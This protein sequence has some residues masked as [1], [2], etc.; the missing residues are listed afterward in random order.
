MD[1]DGEEEP[2]TDYAQR[3]VVVVGGAGFIGRWLVRRL[4]EVGAQVF[5]LEADAAAARRWFAEVGLDADVGA[6][7]ADDAG[8]AAA[9]AARAPDIL[10]NLAAHGVL[11]DER[12]EARF[13]AVNAALPETLARAVASLDGSDWPGQRIVHAGSCSEY[14]LVRGV[15]TERS[16]TSPIAPYG[17]SKLEGTRRLSAFAREHQLRGLVARLLPVYGYGETGGRLLPTLL[18]AAASGAPV[19]LTSG[20]QTRDFV[21]VEDT[22]EGLLRLGVAETPSGHIVNLGSGRVAPV[23]EFVREAAAQLGI[24]EARLRFGAIEDPSPDS[25]HDAVDVSELRRVTGWTPQTTIRDGLRRAI[26]AS[27]Q[28]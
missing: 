20:L 25:A 24:D 27:R 15:L 2:V 19:D 11:R 23:R 9:V 22:V 12:D 17:R 18:R 14:G 6:A 10:F 1:R 4:A 21:Y 7:P 5:V 26:A 3:R 8:V 28:R 13:Q 16:E